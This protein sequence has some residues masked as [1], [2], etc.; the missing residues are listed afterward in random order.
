MNCQYNGFKK[1][2][3]KFK[4]YDE[5]LVDGIIGDYRE[6]LINGF[7]IIE[8]INKEVFKFSFDEINDQY[9]LS[10]DNE[11]TKGKNLHNMF[12]LYVIFGYYAH[13]IINKYLNN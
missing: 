1:D 8:D 6:I 3:K 2:A 12:S 13:E 7:T 11:D 5:Q 10:K 9:S 4:I